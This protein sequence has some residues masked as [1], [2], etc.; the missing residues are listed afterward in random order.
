MHALIRLSPDITTK[1]RGTR[2]RFASRVAS[3][4]ARALASAGL[5]ADV[6]GN[7]V[8]LYMR[9]DDPLALRVACRT[10]GVH[11]VSPCHETEVHDLETLV[12]EGY[13]LAKERVRGRRF[14]VRAK[15][16]DG[17]VGFR[18]RDVDYALG[19]ALTRVGRV[20]LSTP[21]ITVRVEV[22]D[23]TARFFDTVLPGEGGIPLGEGGRAVVLLSGGFDSA[24]AAFAMMRRGVAVDFVSL[25]LGGDTHEQTLLA[26]ANHLAVRWHHGAPT[27]WTCVPFEETVE[28][29]RQRV[30]PRYWQLV[31]KRM[32]Y[33][34][35]EAAAERSG[36][37]VL[38]TGEALGQV[39]SQTLHNLRALDAP[40]R[41]PVLRPL[42]TYD[43]Q[44]IIELARHI[45]THDLSAG[46]E[47]YCGL[48]ARKPA[49]AATV[50]QVAEAEACMPFD[51]AAVLEHARHA[52]L[53][54]H[55]TLRSE[56]GID[57]P[58]RDARLLDL[59]S[60][61]ARAAH[62]L[63]EAEAVEPFE[64][65]EDPA[66]LDAA[67]P[68]VVVCDEGGRGAWF[69]RRLRELGFQAWNL[70]QAG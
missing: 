28:T 21:E 2:K 52:K 8:R 30:E 9:Y 49:T 58:P 54:I 31:L 63:S 12:R 17:N 53:P 40:A 29:M 69:A 41:V 67:L 5:H 51:A 3:N 23:G 61:P 64:I 46:V 70:K 10:F 36:A 65:I 37:Q 45:G 34:V 33:R 25:R 59:R 13:E 55:G 42:L 22:R 15:V 32:M 48:A 1:A 24:V 14:A 50:Q 20:D 39:S 26:V 38:V 11:S 66:R 16:R 56:V 57:S 44:P 62:P 18:S 35:A 7:P 6:D 27:H 4:L 43:K 47:E 60:P 68:Y 19:E